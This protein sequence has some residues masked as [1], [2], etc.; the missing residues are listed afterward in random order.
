MYFTLTGDNTANGYDAMLHNSTGSQNTVVGS[1]AMFTNPSGSNNIA[2]GYK[3]AYNVSGGSDNIELY[4]QGQAGDNG[5]IRIGTENIQTV[6]YMAGIFGFTS[7]NAAGSQQIVTIDNTGNLGSVTVASIAAQGAT[8]AT[9]ADGAAGATGPA[10]SNGATGPAGPAGPTGADSTV[11]G[12]AGATGPAGAVGATGPGLAQPN[13]PSNTGVGFAALVNLTSGTFF[14]TAVGE[15]SM[16]QFSGGNANTAPRGQFTRP[17]GQRQRQHRRRDQRGHQLF[18][19]RTLQHRH[20]RCRSH[21]RIQ[22]APHRGQ[23]GLGLYRR[24]LWGRF[25]Q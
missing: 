19:R 13:G 16:S 1:Q 3:A 25:K 7:N 5:V 20:R 21:R 15:S 8:G 24:H 2:V 23:R 6:A 14:N 9:G 17:P 11:A 10:G 12:P 18:G 22:C 4:D